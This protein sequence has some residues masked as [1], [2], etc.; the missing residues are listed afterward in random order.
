MAGLQFT[1]GIQFRLDDTVW[2]NPGQ[3]AVVVKDASAFE[4]RYGA[5]S[6]ILGTYRGELAN[7][8]E[9]LVMRDP[10]DQVIL[11]FTYGHTDEWPAWAHGFG[12][13]LEVVDTRD[14]Y[15]D[16]GNWRTSRRFGGSPGAEDVTAPGVVI[17]E[18]LTHANLPWTD[19][20][21][22]HNVT[23]IAIDVSG[24]YLSDSANDFRK[25]RI[26]AGTVIPPGGYL[27][28]DEHD[29]NPRRWQPT[30]GGFALDSSQQEDVWLTA[31]DADG[32]LTLV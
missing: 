4:A 3:R 27:V 16:G 20:I 5:G 18:V 32:N 23:E 7:S 26:P 9:R 11:D 29:F 10:F 24:W 2:L 12:S 25:F 17:N 30:A 6:K 22:L 21:E 14:D 13:T 31:T 1:G 8:G 19:Y 15:N 28:F